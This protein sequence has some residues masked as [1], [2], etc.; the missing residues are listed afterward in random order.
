MKVRV[1]FFPMTDASVLT[2]ITLQFD[3]KDLQF[4]AKDGVQKAV[5]NIYGRI[6]TMTRRIAVTPFED[7]VTVD[8]P[9]RDACRR[10]RSN[11][12][13][14]QKTVPL[15]PGTYRLNVVGQRRG[16]RQPEQLRTGDHGAPHR[17]RKGL[18]PAP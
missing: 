15:P 12:R 7:T 3:N 9:D 4:Q 16:R 13:I 2:Y 10:T 1:D 17:H 8:A 14:Y 11:S 6:T 5:V 18:A